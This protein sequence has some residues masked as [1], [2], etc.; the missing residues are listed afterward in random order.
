MAAIVD[1]MRSTPFSV[2]FCCGHRDAARNIL[3]IVQAQWS[4]EDKDDVRYHMRTEQDDDEYNSDEASGDD[5]S[6]TSEPQ[7]MAQKIDQRFTID[8]VGQV[9]MQV[10]S[11]IKPLDLIF[12]SYDNVWSPG[13]EL[14]GDKVRSLLQGVMHEDDTAGLKYLLELIQH[15]ASRKFDGD[16]DNTD[17][18]L[19]IPPADMLFAIKEGKTD[20][21]GLIIK[22]TGVGLP[23]D[24]LVKKTGV[25]LKKKPRYY[26]GL[27]VYGKKRYGWSSVLC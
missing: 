23:V 7:I 26:Q 3:D 12:R 16:E 14:L 8:N 1:D 17:G 10:K 9:S 27:T 25:A 2:A 21:L 19:S 18:V 6:D 5:E 13:G 24:Q 20:F 22:R 4:P 11:R 15:F